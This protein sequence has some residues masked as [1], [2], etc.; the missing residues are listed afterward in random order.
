VLNHQR[1]AVGFDPVKNGFMPF[2]D[3]LI[4]VD[5]A[6]QLVRELHAVDPHNQLQNLKAAVSTLDPLSLRE[7]SD[8]LRD[9]LLADYPQSY[10]QLSTVIK[11][12]HASPSFSGWML[13]PVTSAVATRATEENTAESF[14]DAMELL[15]LLTSRLTSEF[16]IRVLLKHDL[17]SALTFVQ[18][19]TISS[20]EHVRRLAS[21]GTRPFLPWAVRVPEIIQKPDLTIPVL[22]E[23]YKDDSEYVRRSVANHLNDLSR[24]EPELVIQTAGRWLQS[25]APTT[26]KLVKHGLR[27]L[28][29]RGNPEALALLGF[30]TPTVDVNGPLVQ[31]PE[32]PW[33][34]EVNFTATIRN[35]GNEP[36][37][38]AVDYVLH[39]Q[40][41]NGS[42]TAKVFKLTTRTLS[43]GEAMDIDRSHSFKAITTRRYYPGTHAVALQING[44]PTTPTQFELLPERSAGLET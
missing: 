37:K 23:L 12:A 44:V 30:G 32:V 33:G 5:V 2:A 1:F 28:I 41:A 3:Q 38:L 26:V 7:R 24:N 8:T 6:E 35:T 14:N 22:D 9:A 34:G 11:S 40:K 13:W 25:P 42:T 19:W 18:Q 29:K 21:E 39:H 16:A 17:Q 4:G 20:D 27:T 15:A 31:A 10:L 43:P 36:M